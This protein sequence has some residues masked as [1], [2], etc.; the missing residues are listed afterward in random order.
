MQVGFSAVSSFD[1]NDEF[2]KAIGKLGERKFID[3]LDYIGLD[4]YPDVFYL[5]ASDGLPGDIRHGV[6]YMLR[7]F[8]NLW[9]AQSGIPASV[10]MHVSE[11][12][13]PTGPWRSYERQ[14]EAIEAVIRTIYDY[15]GNYN[16]THYE[17]FDLLDANSNDADMLSQFGL[18]R[19][20]YTP[21]PA[22]DVYRKLVSELGIE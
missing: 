2:W 6:E 1:Q 7:M 5:L 21:K 15:R 20:D 22:F 16:V 14:A 13:W 18:L 8:R 11:N 3:S 12:G 10:P 19:D 9:M 17:F 4:F